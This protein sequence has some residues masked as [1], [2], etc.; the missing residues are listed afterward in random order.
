MGRAELWWEGLNCSVIERNHNVILLARG[1]TRAL[2]I[3]PRGVSMCSGVP[4][5]APG[6]SVY[7]TLSPRGSLPISRVSEPA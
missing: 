2:P 4:M 1:A 6:I 5:G 7:Y 3:A